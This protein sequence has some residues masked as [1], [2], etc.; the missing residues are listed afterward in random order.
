MAAAAGALALAG[1][2][3]MARPEASV[4]WLPAGDSDP[5]PRADRGGRGRPAVGH[6]SP[7]SPLLVFVYAI[8]LMGRGAD[9]RFFG[10]MTLFLGAMQTVVLATD[11]LTVLIGFELV[12]TCSWALI[13][14]R[15]DE[16]GSGQRR[17]P[18]LP[19]HP[20]D[21]SRPLPGG[22]GGLRRRRGGWVRDDSPTC[23][24]RSPRSP[25]SAWSS[26]RGQVGPV[27]G[28][29]LAVGRD[30]RAV[31]GVGTAPFLDHGRGRRRAAGQGAAAAG[32]G[33]GGG[34]DGALARHG[35]GAG[36]RRRWRSCRAT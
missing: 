2:A 7:R 18:R 5:D 12:G 25:P 16:G 14:Y 21:R 20:G 15:L 33:A 24:R 19:D 1:H 29:R 36:P 32:G 4:D 27:A 31:A 35:D 3:W 17:Q 9:A 11:L 6:W 28:Q 34:N 10:F 8:G 22:H 13:G 30:A 26:R 23:R